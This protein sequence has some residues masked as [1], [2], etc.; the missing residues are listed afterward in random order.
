MFLAMLG[1][2]CQL[3]LLEIKP[4]ALSTSARCSAT[5]DLEHFPFFGAL[6]TDITLRNA[7]G[8]II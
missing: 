3:C 2:S 6:C 7:S 1:E 5:A 8:V 4:L